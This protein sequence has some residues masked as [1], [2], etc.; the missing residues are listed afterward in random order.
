MFREPVIFNFGTN[1]HKFQARVLTLMLI[2]YA[3]ILILSGF[4]IV[5]PLVSIVA[6][7]ILGPRKPD[8]VKNDI[9]ESGLNTIGDTW[10]QFRAQFYLI[11][12][13][14]LVFDL[15]VIFLFPIALAYGRP[16]FGLA[17]ALVTL[18]FMFLLIVGLIYDW[19][20]GGLEW[21]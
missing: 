15:E 21:Q 13:V 3:F 20:K 11:G 4:G 6:G 7:W 16:E 10:V 19:R 9:Y 18:F 12:L 8:P 1:G 17:A 14:F 5:L 2:N